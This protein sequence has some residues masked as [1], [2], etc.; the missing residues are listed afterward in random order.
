LGM[1][2]IFFLSSKRNNHSQ[3]IQELCRT[4]EI[5]QLFFIC[6]TRH[7]TNKCINTCMNIIRFVW[8]F[9]NTIEGITVRFHFFYFLQIMFWHSI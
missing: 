3:E 8:H 5:R 6:V 1:G 9:H 2:L 7:D 4:I